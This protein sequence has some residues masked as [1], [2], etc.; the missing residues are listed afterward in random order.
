M[1]R[2]LIVEDHE[3]SALLMAETL[4][5]RGHEASIASDASEA[6]AAVA[7]QVPDVVLIDIG[8][9]EVDGYELARRMLDLPQLANRARLIALTGYSGDEARERSRDAGFA[10]HLVK[11]VRPDR[12]L[13]AVEDNA[14][15]Q[16]ADTP[17]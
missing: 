8:L 14:A 13:E 15:F 5:E 4:R 1:R 10:A 16:R 9:P 2:V 17:R 11:P 6:L 7:R 12:L 3:D